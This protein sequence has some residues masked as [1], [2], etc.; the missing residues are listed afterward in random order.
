[1]LQRGRIESC[2]VDYGWHL[3]SLSE[4]PFGT[5]CYKHRVDEVTIRL[6]ILNIYKHVLPVQVLQHGIINIYVPLVYHPRPLHCV[7][8]LQA[9]V[10]TQLA[11]QRGDG[12]TQL[13]SQIGCGSPT[14]NLHVPLYTPHLPILY[15]LVSR[16]C[17]QHN[18]VVVDSASEGYQ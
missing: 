11:K 16:T 12:I 3:D 10:R 9:E 5:L 4:Q 2:T 17:G 6:P 1:G 7:R 14:H 8:I 13:I 15:A 18:R